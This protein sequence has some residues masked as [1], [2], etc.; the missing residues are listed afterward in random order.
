ML[1]KVTN[2][3]GFLR[4]KIVK[5]RKLPEF[6]ENELPNK[7]DTIFLRYVDKL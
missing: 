2:M 6:T 1:S 7:G 4:I 5:I 3:A